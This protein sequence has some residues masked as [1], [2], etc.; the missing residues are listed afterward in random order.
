MARTRS[1]N[2]RRERRMTQ[3]KSDDVYFER[4]RHILAPGT[5][6]PLT[7]GA[8]FDGRQA[9]LDLSHLRMYSIMVQS[10][11]ERFQ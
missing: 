10:V 1:P 2:A 6:V 3:V 5:A 4:K 7:C 8:Q 11:L 9:R